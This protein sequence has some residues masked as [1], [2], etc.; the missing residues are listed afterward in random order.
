MDGSYNHPRVKEKSLEAALNRAWGW[1]GQ[2]VGLDLTKVLLLCRVGVSGVP[3]GKTEVDYRQMESKQA[4]C[5]QVPG[6]T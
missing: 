4:A 6:V 2:E 5:R 1:F 3:E